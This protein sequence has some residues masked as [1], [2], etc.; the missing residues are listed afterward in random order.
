MRTQCNT[1]SFALALYIAEIRRQG[2][3]SRGEEISLA[4]EAKAGAPDARDAL[5][6]ANLGFVVKVAKGYRNLG[7][8]F[9]ELINEGN[10]G[11]IEAARRFDP[12][13]GCKFITFAIWWIRKGILRAL[14]EQTGVVRVPNYQQRRAREIRH[15][16]RS[17]SR[18][19]GRTPERDEISREASRSIEEVDELMQFGRAGTG[20]EEPIRHHGDDP[21][22]ARLVGGSDACPERRLLNQ[23]ATKLVAEA[24][25]NLSTQE[26]TIICSRYG[27]AGEAPR[28]LREI[29]DEMG[30]SR[31]RIRQ[32][33]NRAIEQLRRFL[34]ARHGRCGLRQPP[35]VKEPSGSPGGAGIP[36]R[37]CRSQG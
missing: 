17:L 5:I 18:A 2:L 34:E 33:E 19:L 24:I 26:R 31:E 36:S 16:E 27:L 25:G 37:P 29:G 14:G 13:R 9:E 22:A 28:V 4:I 12:S 15:V 23:E 35:T 10:L 7:L 30:L 32:I 1:D 3:L 20:V 8:P 6:Q 21:I 11:L